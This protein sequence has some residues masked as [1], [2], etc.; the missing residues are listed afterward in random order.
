MINEF[1]N[2]SFPQEQQVPNAIEPLAGVLVLVA[3]DVVFLITR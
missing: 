2:T 3:V 1:E